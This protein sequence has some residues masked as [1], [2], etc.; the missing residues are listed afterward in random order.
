MSDP[1]RNG[2]ARSK[3]RHY[4]EIDERHLELRA[5]PRV[6]EVAVRQHGG[7][8]ADGGTLHGR[9]QR[10]VEVDQ[11]IHQPGLRRFS[12]TWRILQEVLHIVA[13]A[14]RISCAVPEHDT[15]ALVLGRLVED[16]RERHVHARG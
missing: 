13:G 16:I 8:A 2:T 7:A 10:L 11:R 5:T 3:F 9:D 14:E 4:S 15:R 12:W 6:Y 1:R